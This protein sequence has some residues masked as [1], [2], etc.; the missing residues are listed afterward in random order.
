VMLIPDEFQVEDQLWQSIQA[1]VQQPL[2]RA[3][4]QRLLNEWLKQ[5]NFPT[6]DLLPV[7]RAVA[8]L[9]DRRKHVYHE[10]DTHF[11]AR[12]NE[13]CAQ[14]LAEFLKTHE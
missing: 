1:Q 3:R 10:R 4:P 14:A 7:L 9:G 5:H 13:A 2:E 11:N 8:P 12:G 6:L